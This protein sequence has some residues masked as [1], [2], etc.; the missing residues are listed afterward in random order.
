MITVHKIALDPNNK[1]R[2][3]FARAAGVARFAYNWALAE[4]QRQ[5]KNGEKPNEVK[6]RR[7]LNALKRS[8]FPWML[9]VTKAAPQ[10]AIKNLGKGYARA[11][12]NVKIGRKRGK[13]NPYG[14]PVF[15][16][17]GVHDSFR[18]D[19]GPDKNHPNAVEIEGK[20]VK[21]P[22]IGWIRMHE[23]LRFEGVIKSAVVSREADRW[24]VA[25][26]VEIEAPEQRQCDTVVGVDLGVKDLAVVSDGRRFKASKSLRLNLQRLRRANKELS[27]RKKKSANW[28]KTKAKLAKLHSRIS[29]L[30]KDCLHKATT[31]IV[32]SAGV[33]VLEDL[34]VSGMMANGKLSRAIADVGLYEFRRQT[35]YKAERSGAKVIFANRWFPSSKTCNSCGCIKDKLPLSVREWTCEHCGAHHD[36]D[37]NAAINLRNLAASSAVAACGENSAG[38]ELTPIVKLASVKQEYSSI[39]TYGQLCVGL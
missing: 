1:Q 26:S 39:A 17:K 8:Q 9:E 25:L 27:R 20:K 21:L 7:E 32:R 28:L 5:H 33:I 18:A 35:E 3:Y 11:F 24:F 38:D 2:T 19:N 10:Q 16:K 13:K 30:R 22:V 34:N 23:K 14:F 15:K 31:D 37:L 6:L 12:K 36:R 4:W 29:N